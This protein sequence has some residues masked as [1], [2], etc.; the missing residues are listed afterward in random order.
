MEAQRTDL[1]RMTPAEFFAFAEK[2]EGR[3]EFRAGEVVAMSGGTARHARLASRLQGLLFA[4]LRGTP[5]SAFTSELHLAIEAA[6]RYVH[7][8]NT[9]VCGPLQFAG[10]DA[11]GRAVTN[12]R[13][14]IEVLSDSTEA[15]DRGEKFD[16]YR[17]IPTFEEYILV[18]RHEPDVQSFLR[19]D[20]GTW[21]LAFS[22]GLDA[23]AT[24]RCLPLELPLAELY[25]E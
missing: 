21:N 18:S 7:P 1:P 11:D 22:R 8:D 17:Q 2:Q 20:D 9:V 10:G 4:G 15:H 13:V 23:V 3:Y 16:L 12:A 6:D 24:I 14:V 25:A 19:Q 5:C